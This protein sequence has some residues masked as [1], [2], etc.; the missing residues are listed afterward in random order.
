MNTAIYFGISAAAGL[1]GWL[2]I[3]ATIIWPKMKDQPRI[4]KLKTFNGDFFLPLLRDNV[5]DYR[6]RNTQ[7]ACRVRGSGGVWRPYRPGPCVYRLYRAP[8][9]Q[10]RKAAP[11]SNMDLQYRLQS[12]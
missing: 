5:F 4:Q 11:V 1:I 2:T 6:P 7:V 10:D 9:V 3:F 12:T 8:A